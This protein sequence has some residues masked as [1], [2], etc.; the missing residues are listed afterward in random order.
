MP[1]KDFFFVF[2]IRGIYIIVFS[3]WVR[4]NFECMWYLRAQ[5]HICHK[6]LAIF[7]NI[8]TDKWVM[9]KENASLH[10][11]QQFQF[12]DK[13]HIAHSPDNFQ[14][15]NEYYVEKWRIQYQPTLNK[16]KFVV[17]F[18]P[19]CRLFCDLWANKRSVTLFFKYF[20]YSFVSI[21]QMVNRHIDCQTFL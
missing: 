4:A 8:E 3:T 19:K 9:N 21:N 15:L 7:S 12:H 11:F 1:F 10:F 20:F 2:L 17:G 13:S 16:G 14:F 6:I 18:W 5:K